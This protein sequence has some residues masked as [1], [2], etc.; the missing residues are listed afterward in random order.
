MGDPQAL[1]AIV[2]T[3]A[4]QSRA[5]IRGREA[6]AHVAIEVLQGVRPHVVTEL[7]QGVSAYRH[8]GAV[9]PDGAHI[10]IDAGRILGR[11]LSVLQ[12]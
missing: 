9:E 11:T 4:R 6:S 10:L 3:Y 5:T 12:V 1:R 2:N 8:C 7:L